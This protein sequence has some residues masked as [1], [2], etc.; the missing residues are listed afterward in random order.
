[1][2][3]RILFPYVGDSVGGSHIS[4]L[5][6]ARGLPERYAPVIA[7]HE[8]GPLTQYLV[9]LGMPAIDAPTVGFLN[10]GPYR[11]QFLKAWRGVPKLVHF[12][13]EQ[14]I[15]LV[16][17]HD[18]R[19]H[20]IWGLAAKRAGIPHIWH[21]R[22]PTTAKRLDQ[23][24][25][26]A[27]RI[28]AVSDYCRSQFPPKMRERAQI[29][30]NPFDIPEPANRAA[31]R[32]ALAGR[33]G[34]G[35]DTKVIG[36][37]ANLDDRKRPLL[38]VEIAQKLRAMGCNDLHFIM[39]GEARSP[40]IEVLK[41]K[42]ADASL[43][44]T[45]QH[46]GPQYPIAPWMA[47]MDLLIAPAIHEALGRTMIEAQLFGTPVVA[48]N[49]GGNPEIILDDTTGFLAEPDNADDFAAKAL[50][51]LDD[52]ALALRLTERGKTR[53]EQTFSAERHISAMV[54]IYEDVL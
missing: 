38:F 19:M 37:I 4:S 35:S 27:A 31:A 13:R 44:E 20:V 29:L 52:P 14:R 3:K 1:M 2:T 49:A 22:T 53:A 42:I 18:I 33:L 8:A 43:R 32:T 7:Q 40:H 6:L 45:V 47:G 30:F 12:L 5:T 26:H 36:F 51:L 34:L 54:D 25:S 48:S 41:Q 17:T 21:Q 15:D 16:H 50:R 11:K 39:L 24:T 46:I 28:L 9:Q 10:T 23:Y